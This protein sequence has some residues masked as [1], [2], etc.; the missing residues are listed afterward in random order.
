M[1]DLKKI[2]YEK[3]TVLLTKCGPEKLH[4]AGLKTPD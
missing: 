1:I 2:Q 3:D 4:A